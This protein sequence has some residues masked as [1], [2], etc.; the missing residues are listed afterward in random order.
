M[1][2][3]ALFIQNAIARGSCLTLH[4]VDFHI[5][6][7]SFWD[8][9]TFEEHCRF[10]FF[11]FNDAFLKK[12]SHK[13]D[14]YSDT[15]LKSFL[16][17]LNDNPSPYKDAISHPSDPYLYFCGKKLQSL[18]QSKK[19]E[20]VLAID[21]RNRQQLRQAILSHLNMPIHQTK[22]Q[23]QREPFTNLLKPYNGNKANTFRKI[24]DYLSQLDFR[25]DLFKPIS[26]T[27][28]HKNPIGFN[29]C[30][31]AMITVFKELGY[32]EKAYSFD[33]ILDA[34]IEQTGN[35]I[36]NLGDFKNNYRKKDLFDRYRKELMEL[37]I[38]SFQ[39]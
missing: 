16:D 34:Y 33:D 13:L 36:G 24:Q 21:A 31:A 10:L 22:Q 5:K 2:N 23:Q 28:G 1:D 32:F 38:T 18:N 14:A 39:N 12:I 20:Q 9:D 7:H 4:D 26:K 27:K 15:A 37:H 29:A 17:V 6:A 19:L 3:H 30:V 35:T 11:T 25:H 8:I